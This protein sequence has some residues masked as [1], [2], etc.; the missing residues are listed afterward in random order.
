[1][2]NIYITGI[3]GFVGQN[4]NHFLKKDYQ[5]KGI[6]RVTSPESLSYTEFFQGN[7]SYDAIVHLAG[8]AHDL[9]KTADDA[10]YYEVNYEL[11]KKLYDHF[12]QSTAQKFIY[13]SSVKAAADEVEGILDENVVPKPVTVYGKSKLKAEEYIMQNLPEDKEVYILRPCMIHG[14]GNKGNL[15]LLY[16][17]VAKG[18][19]YPLGAYKNERSFLSVDN[20]CFVIEQLLQKKVPSGIY[21]IADDFSLATT[22]IVSLAGESLERK[23][24][25]LAVPQLVIKAIAKLGDIAPLPINSER[26]QKLTENYVVSNAKIKKALGIEL[27]LSSREGLIK[28]FQSFRK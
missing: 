12:V 1:M 16:S 23:A 27:P 4:L 11:T 10:A 6:S 26:L 7:N 25:I 21:N 9:K 24:T 20:L 5:L 22:D 18:I 13:I 2:K 3:T 8:K 15:N 17:I 14:P 28:T 19:P